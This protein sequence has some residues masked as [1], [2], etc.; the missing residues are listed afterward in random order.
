MAISV[1]NAEEVT[2]TITTLVEADNVEDQT[3]DNLGVIANVLDDISNLITDDVPVD[4]EFLENVSPT[5]DTTLN[6]PAFVNE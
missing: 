4:Q 5:L 6:M 1:E 2:S 3:T